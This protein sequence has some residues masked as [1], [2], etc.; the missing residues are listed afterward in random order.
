MHLGKRRIAARQPTERCCIPRHRR[1]LTVLSSQE[2]KCYATL[3]RRVA[4]AAAAPVVPCSSVDAAGGGPSKHVLRSTYLTAFHTAL[5]EQR[6]NASAP[7][8]AR[9]HWRTSAVS[10]NRRQWRLASSR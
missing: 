1:S 9:R 10:S 6:S 3:L 2:A 8:G 4:H 7:P 5:A